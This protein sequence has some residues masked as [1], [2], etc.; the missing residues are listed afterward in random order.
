[1][2]LTKLKRLNLLHSVPVSI[3]SCL[4]ARSFFGFG[5]FKI[6]I[7]L[8]GYPVSVCWNVPTRYCSVLG[9]VWF[10]LL[11][12][13]PFLYGCVISLLHRLCV[14]LMILCRW[15][16]RCVIDVSV[17]PV[18]RLPFC[19]FVDAFACARLRF[20]LFNVCSV[21]FLVGD[22]IVFVAH[23]WCSSSGIRVCF[24]IL[25]WVM[26]IGA[27]LLLTVLLV[28]KGIGLFDLTLYIGTLQAFLPLPTYTLSILENRFICFPVYC[29]VSYSVYDLFW[30]WDRSTSL[31]FVNMYGPCYERC[32]FLF[33]DRNVFWYRLQLYLSS[34][35][36]IVRK[37]VQ[38]H[39]RGTSA[40]RWY[41]L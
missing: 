30:P 7:T 9:S 2:E 12:S 37:S 20:V 26:C 21:R 39:L 8:C 38:F 23:P 18:G 29:L 3:D 24:V 6:V 36:V 31:H 1:M 17:G 28:R 19:L 27:P 32:T 10:L 13:L 34:I 16:S 35:V 22:V 40:C 41:D 25:C 33:Y 14:V 5:R 4:L 15:L 11:V